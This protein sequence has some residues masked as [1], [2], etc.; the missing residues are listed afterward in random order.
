MDYESKN[1][2][3]KTPKNRQQVSIGRMPGFE[4]Q[5]SRLHNEAYFSEID[6]DDLSEDFLKQYAGEMLKKQQEIIK[7]LKEKLNENTPVKNDKNQNLSV[8]NSLG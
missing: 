1:E 5:D 6:F 8:S 3:F 7:E 4:Q 2:N